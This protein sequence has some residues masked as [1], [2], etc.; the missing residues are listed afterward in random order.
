MKTGISTFKGKSF[1]KDFDKEKFIIES[2]RIS[3]ER[4]SDL[5][6]DIVA[7][8]NCRSSIVGK[9]ELIFILE[10]TINL[11]KFIYNYKWINKNSK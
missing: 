10:N 7:R 4:I 1:E 2:K 6:R 5:E 9:H 3:L 11:N 8:K